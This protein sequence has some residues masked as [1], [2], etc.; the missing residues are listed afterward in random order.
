METWQLAILLIWGAGTATALVMGK[1]ITVKAVK[2]KIRQLTQSIIG[3]DEAHDKRYNDLPP[4][5]KAR[6]DKRM[7]QI[8]KYGGTAAYG[9][10]GAILFAVAG[11]TGAWIIPLALG[12]RWVKRNWEDQ[13]NTIAEADR[14]REQI[15]NPP[16]PVGNTAGVLPPTRARNYW[17]PN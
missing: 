10:G 9:I 5:G 3:W 16:P 14:C 4:L 2:P 6:V 12:G 1:R 7:A 13:S 8:A 15:L 11:V 17:D